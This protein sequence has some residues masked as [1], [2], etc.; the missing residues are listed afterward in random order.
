MLVTEALVSRTIGN[1]CIDFSR[2]RPDGR[3]TG[4]YQKW[5]NFRIAGDPGATPIEHSI[6]DSAKLA[7]DACFLQDFAVRDLSFSM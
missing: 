6:Y 2:S 4:P 5:C 1:N 7:Y 3:P